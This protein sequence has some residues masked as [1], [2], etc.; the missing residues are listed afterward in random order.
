MSTLTLSNL[1]N[2]SSSNMVDLSDTMNRARRTVKDLAAMYSKMPALEIRNGMTS[3]KIG[4]RFG[5]LKLALAGVGLVLCLILGSYTFVIAKETYRRFATLT[6]Q[7]TGRT[8]NSQL[9]NA[10]ANIIQT[11]GRV[12]RR[13]AMSYANWVLESST[14]WSV[15]PM[16]VMAVMSVESGFNYQLVSSGNAVGLMQVIHSWH[17]EKVDKASLL[18]P[19]TN[20]DVGTQIISEYK[21]MSSSE[22]EAL[23]RYNGSLGGAGI[24][25]AKVMA[26]KVAYNKKVI[27][28]LTT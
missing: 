16:T 24:Y 15:D 23:L 3:P 27:D 10:M 1:T 14:K 13:L 28:Q 5:K 20:I 7:I 18:D 2:G 26:K 25:A 19:R 8:G 11:E 21:N 6:E 9:A 12:D 22:A 4:T 17:K